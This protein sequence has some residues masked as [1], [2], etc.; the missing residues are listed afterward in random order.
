MPIIFHG[1]EYLYSHDKK[2]KLNHYFNSGA[3]WQVFIA[4]SC[5]PWFWLTLI[6]LIETNT[7]TIC[8]IIN[9]GKE[10]TNT[11]LWS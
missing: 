5:L 2:P 4:R 7:K 8:K 9:Y 6:T 3:I 1:C 11:N 10:C